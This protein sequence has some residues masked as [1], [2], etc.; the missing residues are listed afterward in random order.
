MIEYEKVL[1]GIN[2]VSDK[3]P[4]DKSMS[5][6]VNTIGMVT[7]LL[8]EILNVWG[9]SIWIIDKRIGRFHWRDVCDIAVNF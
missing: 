5:G 3:G 9:P 4:L 1:R 7:M 8:T 6:R 2:S